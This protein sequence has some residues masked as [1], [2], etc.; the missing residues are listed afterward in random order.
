MQSQLPQQTGQRPSYSS[1]IMNRLPV[2]SLMSP[3][4]AKPLDSFHPSS[5]FAKPDTSMG[6]LMKLPPISADRKRTQSEMDLPS[7]PVTP[8]TGAKKRRSETA[9]QIERDVEVNASRD[10]LLFPRHDSVG[11]EEPLFGPIPL[12]PR[13]P[14]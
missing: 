4:E 7:P 12:Q 9:E 11:R 3:P 2:S 13:R 5:P 8:Y 10:P 14:W 1:S 6:E